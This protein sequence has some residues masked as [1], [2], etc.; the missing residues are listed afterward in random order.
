MRGEFYGEIDGQGRKIGQGRYVYPNR[1]FAYEG[2]FHEDRKDGRGKL[3]MADGSVYVGEFAEGEMT[4]EGELSLTTGLSYKGGFL[5]GERHGEGVLRT[6]HLSYTGQFSHGRFEGRGVL[7]RFVE[8]KVYNGIFCAGVME[9]EFEISSWPDAVP[10]FHGRLQQGKKVGPGTLFL[11]KWRLLSNFV[12]NEPE[13]QVVLELEGTTFKYVGGFVQ[14]RPQ[15]VATI[16]AAE[17]FPLEEKRTEKPGK[18]AARLKIEIG[19]EYKLVLSCFFQPPNQFNPDFDPADKKKQGKVPEFIT[20]DP[21]LTKEESGRVFAYS[22][23]EEFGEGRSM[24][25]NLAE[26]RFKALEQIPSEEEITLMSIEGVATCKNFYIDS[27]LIPGNYNVVFEDT[28]EF[29]GEWF[30]PLSSYSLKVEVI[31]SKKP[32]AK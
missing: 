22:F 27:C 12:D 11:G 25:I 7:E 14:G 1:F 26:L 3:L 28:T 19:E 20:P 9:G 4:G 30:C 31:A 29:E 17:I 18:A 15:V 5:R 16:L 32:K 13:E 23:I 6:L 21:L 8:K 10:L 24:R 2:E